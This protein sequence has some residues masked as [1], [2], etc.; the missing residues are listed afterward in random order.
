MVKVMIV[1][2]ESLVTLQLSKYISKLGYDVIPPVMSGEESI[3]LARQVRPDL[4]FMDV[5]MPGKYDGIAAAEIIKREMDIP[6]VFVSGYSD[7]DLLQRAKQVEPLGYILKPFM[8]AEVK[9]VLELALYRSE[10]ERRLKERE[11][12]VGERSELLPN[13]VC[14]LNADLRVTY[15]NQTGFE[16]LGYSPADLD[17]PLEIS[18]LIHPDD[19]PLALKNMTDSYINGMTNENECLLL[20]KG[21][22]PVAALVQCAPIKRDGETVGVRCSFT[23][24]TEM[25]RF[26]EQ[27]TLDNQLEAISTLV[28]GIAHDF[29]NLLAIIIGYMELARIDSPPQAIIHRHLGQAM[30]ACWSAKHLTQRLLFLSHGGVPNIISSDIIELIKEAVALVP[31]GPKVRWEY[32][33]DDHLWPVDVDPQQVR[34]ALCNI[35]GNA[36]QAMVNGGVINIIV[37]NYLVG[38][39]PRNE[40]PFLPEGKYVRICIADQGE[41]IPEEL[42]PRIFDPYFSTKPRGARKGMGL[43]LTITHAIIKR[44]RGHIRVESVPGNGTRVYIYLPA[45]HMPPS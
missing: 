35:V 8:E 20:R 24:I 44:H 12:S 15:L 25:R 36:Q 37:E 34:Q 41:G 27:L 17:P 4:I 16:T 1:D 38:V 14:E 33:F 5:L 30:D 39:R 13:I 40:S 2:D 11:K 28:G 43:G 19:Q 42:L 45:A 23:D 6:V 26:R 3:D 21:G 32:C 31:G 18:N 9:A 10:M 22:S 7:D 29:N